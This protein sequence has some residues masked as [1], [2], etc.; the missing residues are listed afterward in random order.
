MILFQEN[1]QNGL[2]R[3]TG[4]GGGAHHGLVVPDPLGSKDNALVFTET[5]VRVDLVSPIIQNSGTNY[6]L[7]F[8]YLGKPLD[9]TITDNL[10][11]FIGIGDLNGITRTYASTVPLTSDSGANSP[12]ALKDDSTWHHYTIPFSAAGGS[13]R[14]TLEDW[15]FDGKVPNRAGDCYFKNIMVTDGTVAPT[16]M[17]IP[18]STMPIMQLS[19]ST[20]MIP[21]WPDA[22]RCGDEIRSRAIFILHDVAAE[23]WYVQVYPYEFRYVRFNRDGSYNS[24]NGDDGSTRGCLNQSISQLYK[25]GRA[26]NFVTSKLA[27]NDGVSTMVKGW[28]DALR[29]GAGTSPGAILISQ[30]VY[31]G[32]W[33]A[34]VDPRQDSNV[35][36]NSDKN[37]YSKRGHDDSTR[38]CLGQSISQLYDAGRA[39]NFITSKSADNTGVSTMIQG[40]PDALRCG[41]GTHPG[42]MFILHD[43][44]DK[45]WYIQVYSHFVYVSFDSD[46][47]YNS[48][49]GPGDDDSKGCLDQ[50]ISQLYKA[51]R[52]FN[53]VTSKSADNPHPHVD[54]VSQDDSILQRL[55]E[56]ER[57]NSEQNK[58]LERYEELFYHGIF[59]SFVIASS[60][61][62]GAKLGSLAKLGSTMFQGAAIGVSLGTAACV[63]MHKN[64][65][66]DQAIK[67][68]GDA[69]LGDL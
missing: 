2:S 22:L 40:W 30:D 64:G 41:A 68:I 35:I 63:L 21:G 9:D 50:S 12:I 60:L 25:R 38:G 19:R 51:G 18:S 11:C 5:N 42:A 37:Y 46:G 20:T 45:A 62:V 32:A 53:F 66:T 39:F 52:A 58:K 6:I 4:K 16:I 29:C 13:I 26:F 10:G 3:W 36:F 44:A 7:S 17:P 43:V 14:L 27:D 67:L 8:D 54:T 15:S 23:A 49:G 55:S 33:Y 31:T 65:I 69:N 47:N 59:Y 56:L 28:P 61:V 1:F 24:R 48:R 57:I 34:Q